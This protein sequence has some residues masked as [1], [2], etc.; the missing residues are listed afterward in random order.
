MSYLTLRKCVGGI[1]ALLPFVLLIGNELIGHGTE[2]SMS[3]YYYTPMR[4]VW[5][6][7]LC[8]LGIFLITYDGWDLPDEVIT[9]IAG[10]STLGAA[11]CP[12]T[13]LT[14]QVTAREMTVGT[15][16]LA[17][18]AV[19]FLMLGLMSLRFATRA[20]MPPGL[21]LRKRIGYALGF[22]P[23]GDSTAT[24]A[25][26]TVYRA[27]GFVILVGVAIFYPMTKA[28]WDWLLVLEAVM[29]VAFGVAWFLKGTTLPGQGSAPA[30]AQAAGGPSLSP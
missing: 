14:G 30:Q 18:A 23:P 9:N 12:T 7:A 4:N 28:G 25:E 8:A 10:V 1:G 11:L 5:V 27:S 6:G 26:I 20:A 17:F 3:A 29:L 16:H 21:P 13:P 15:F 24:A 19:T 22:T 2:P